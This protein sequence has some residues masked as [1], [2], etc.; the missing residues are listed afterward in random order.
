MNTACPTCTK[1]IHGP[2]RICHWCGHDLD[3]ARDA[4]RRAYGLDSDGLLPP[5]PPKGEV[6]AILRRVLA[7]DRDRELAG[8]GSET[9]DEYRRRVIEG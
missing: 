4:T 6:S 9:L 2:S 3:A 1:T 5:A 8:P 7:G